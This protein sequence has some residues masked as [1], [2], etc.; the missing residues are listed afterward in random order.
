MKEAAA[1]LGVGAPLLQAKPLQQAA[2]LLQAKPL[3]PTKLNELK[4]PAAAIGSGRLGQMVGRRKIQNNSK[5]KSLN[6][7]EVATGK[8]RVANKKTLQE[9]IFVSNESTSVKH[10]PANRN[11]PTL[12]KK[13]EQMI[14]D[15]STPAALFKSQTQQVTNMPTLTDERM[16]AV[17]KEPGLVSDKSVANRRMRG[18]SRSTIFAR[19]RARS[20]MANSNS[21]KLPQAKLVVKQERPELGGEASKSSRKRVLN[22]K[23]CQNLGNLRRSNNVQK[24]KTASKLVAKKYENAVKVNGAKKPVVKVENSLGKRPGDEEEVAIEYE[25][26]EESACPYCLKQFNCWEKVTAHMGKVHADEY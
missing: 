17:K 26:R 4:A 3:H 11:L 1:A 12:A 7:T 10:F 8:T 16:V 13:C 19:S 15:D 21:G 20:I 24:P 18:I 5:N 9:K 2:P 22:A 25:E 6:K 23:K 14:S